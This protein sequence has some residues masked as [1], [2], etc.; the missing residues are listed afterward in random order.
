MKCT[1]AWEYQKSHICKDVAT[2]YK[3]AAI[4][5]AVT[6]RL[7]RHIVWLDIDTFFQRDLDARFWRF[8]TKFDVVTI[9]R[10]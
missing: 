3:V 6:S 4:H 5:D 8:V 7:A 2:V 9:G 10:K 1:V